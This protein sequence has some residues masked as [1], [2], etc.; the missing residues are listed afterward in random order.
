MLADSTLPLIRMS[1]TKPAR[2]AIRAGGLFLS[3][4]V[5][6]LEADMCGRF[7]LTS[8]SHALHAEFGIEQIPPDYRPR[9]NIAP[10]QPVLAIVPDAQG[11]C[12]RSLI[13]GLVPHWSKDRNSATRHINARAE[14]LLEKRTFRAAFEQRRCLIIA[15]GFFEW[16]KAGPYSRPVL[17]RRHDGRP[18][19]FAGIWERWRPTADA[20]IE[21][22]AIITT[23]PNP[24]LSRIHDRMPVIIA[25]RDREAWLESDA[26]V[27]DLT[28]LLRPYPDDE[29]ELVL[30]SALVNSPAND[31]VECI[32]PV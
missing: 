16:E 4:T 7:T 24:L 2:L 19:T 23:E 32:Q 27:T 5:L 3:L 31:S 13:W 15:D 1:K 22:C 25:P 10:T 26:S 29:L 6:H 30:V 14:S 11:W 17:I 20:A 9:Y 18:F 21:T 28:K 12:A 8:D